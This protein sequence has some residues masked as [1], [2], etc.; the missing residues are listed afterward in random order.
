MPCLLSSSPWR[1]S[2]RP[3]GRAGS[4]IICRLAV[5]HRPS[6][7]ESC[8][9]WKETAFLLATVEE[10]QA[11][12]RPRRTASEPQRF[13]TKVEFTDS[14]W[15]WTAGKSSFGYGYFARAK[16][17]G[18]VYAHRWAYEHLVGPVLE[19]LE[20]DHLCRVPSCVNP[21]H[22][23]PVTHQENVRRGLSPSLLRSWRHAITHCPQGHAYD[24][25]NT[26][27]K[28][29]CRSCRTCNYAG[30]MRRYYAKKASLAGS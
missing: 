24:E 30:T 8:G 26:I 1:G 17:N 25:A 23:E 6:Q 29:G 27:L 10:L 19:G 28:H 7:C 21:N 2:T 22:L 18:H 14:C 11:I 20:L 13:W 12:T 15:L 5:S 9:G 16:A 3:A 4:A